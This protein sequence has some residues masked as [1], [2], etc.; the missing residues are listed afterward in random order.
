MPF[1]MSGYWAGV[2]TV[3]LA[4]AAGFGGGTMIADL[5]ASDTAVPPPGMSRL[6]RSDGG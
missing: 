2:G 3:V 5:V 1:S 4:L 6:E